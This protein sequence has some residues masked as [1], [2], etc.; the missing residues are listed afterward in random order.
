MGEASVHGVPVIFSGPP[1]DAK[2]FGQVLA[3]P[4]FRHWVHQKHQQFLVRRVEV[5]CIDMFGPTQNKVGFVHVRVE[6]FEKDTRG[7][8]VGPPLPGIAILRGPTVAIGVVINLVGIAPEGLPRRWFAGTRQPRLPASVPMY[9]EN[10]HHRVGLVE[11]CAAGMADMEYPSE[12]DPVDGSNEG[13]D[14]AGYA[15]ASWAHVRGNA[16]AQ[17]LFEEMGIA[18]QPIQDLAY[19][20]NTSQGLLDERVYVYGVTCDMTWAELQRYA[21]TK[22][23]V[24]GEENITVTVVP[25]DEVF[26]LGDSK[27]N[28]FKLAYECYE[29]RGFPHADDSGVGAGGLLSRCQSSCGGGN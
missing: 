9:A 16:A 12:T 25:W 7:K 23:G 4:P 22:G 24:E 13:G 11:E 18:D 2:H 15:E 1:D 29:T 8:P 21:G 10:H 17:E 28:A 19:S 26:A 14:G 6:A 27:A 5:R 3:H 20:F